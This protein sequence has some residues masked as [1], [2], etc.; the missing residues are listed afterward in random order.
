MDTGIRRI[1]A[2]I[3]S[4]IATEHA[5]RPAIV[6]VDIIQRHAGNA[7]LIRGLR[8]SLRY[9]DRAGVD[10]NRTAADRSAAAADAQAGTRNAH[11]KRMAIVD[12]GN[13]LFQIKRAAK[14]GI[15]LH[16]NY[17]T[18]NSI[19]QS[20]IQGLIRNLR[21][22]GLLYHGPNHFLGRRVGSLSRTLCC[23]HSRIAAGSRLGIR[24]I[25][26]IFSHHLRSNAAY[27]LTACICRSRHKAQAHGDK[28]QQAHQLCKC[29]HVVFS[30][31][32][33]IYKFK[34]YDGRMPFID[35]VILYHVAFVFARETCI[36]F[37]IFFT[38][39]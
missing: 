30:F 15:S 34:S 28:Q 24:L 10:H 18:G 36:I 7:R 2:C 1:A 27:V 16:N 17:F 25:P 29:F 4:D 33:H 5:G 37:S 14:A 26:G 31:S 11:R 22:I 38:K 32:V 9:L 23:L 8:L 6:H 12:H 20:G 39:L 13:L 21:T 35:T 3:N 19:R